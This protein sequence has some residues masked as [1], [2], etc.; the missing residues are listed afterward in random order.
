MPDRKTLA[1]RPQ[2]ARR[3]Q[4]AR[5]R[6]RL[7]NLIQS[8]LH[9]HLA[10]PC[11]PANL[12]GRSGRKWI[13]GKPV[14]A[15]ERDAID[16]HLAQIDLIEASVKTVEAAIAGEAIAEPIIRRLMTLPGVDM[17]VANCVAASAARRRHL[18]LPTVSQLLP[19]RAVVRGARSLAETAQRAR[20][21]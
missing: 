17:I 2:V 12:V 19:M 6:V 8:I 10:P 11:L 7:K 4:L 20:A 14:P 1:L 15:D 5:Q 13:A 3:T 18:S 21:A 9:T 16:Q